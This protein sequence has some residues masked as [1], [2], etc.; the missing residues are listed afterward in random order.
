M[1][2]YL[3]CINSPNSA[4]KLRNLLLDRS[5]VR[6]LLS[7]PMSPGK[8]NSWLSLRYNAVK[9]SNSHNEGLILRTQPVKMIK[10][11]LQ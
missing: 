9:C 3:N 4:G 11:K 10:D 6:K 5:S 2:V 7:K 1:Q 8:R